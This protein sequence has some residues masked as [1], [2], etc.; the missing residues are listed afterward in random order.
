MSWNQP[1]PVP[2]DQ[3]AGLAE[4]RRPLFLT[5]QPTPGEPDLQ[6]EQLVEREPAAPSLAVLL[7]PRSVEGV[8]RI[9]STRK[10]RALGDSAHSESGQSRTCGSALP[11]SSRSF[12]T[13]T[14][15]LAG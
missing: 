5:A 10:P 3:L 6:D 2:R 1:F 4:S 9:G 13:V 15:S 14:S 7:V 8:K 11:T 12:L